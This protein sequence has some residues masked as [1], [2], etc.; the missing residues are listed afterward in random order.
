M[1]TDKVSAFSGTTEPTKN[2]PELANVK[3]AFH[4]GNLIYNS[5]DNGIYN[6]PSCVVLKKL[7]LLIL[8][9]GSGGILPGCQWGCCPPQTSFS[10]FLCFTTSQT[11]APFPDRLGIFASKW[12][13]FVL[14]LCLRLSGG[15]TCWKVINEQNCHRK[16]S[17]CKTG[18]ITGGVTAFPR[19]LSK[20]R[21]SARLFLHEDERV[22]GDHGVEAVEPNGPKLQTEEWS[23]NLS[24]V[25]PFPGLED[26]WAR[27][28]QPQH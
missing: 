18:I 24:S 6:S 22:L 3:N 16:L 20:G 9:W 5:C 2:L 15:C 23:Q 12:Q 17:S 27:L 14:M 8:E 10:Y 1:K 25:G 19:I 7:G 11:A 26:A 4:Y 21:T 28:F 13:N